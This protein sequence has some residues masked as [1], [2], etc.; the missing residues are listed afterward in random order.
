MAGLHKFEI[1]SWNVEGLC[2]P[3]RKHIVSKWMADQPGQLAFLCLQEIK[4]EGFRLDTTLSLI[5]PDH[6]AFVSL[7]ILGSGGTGGTAILVHPE[8]V[9][10]DLGGFQK[11]QVVWVIVEWKGC[12]FGVMNI[13]APNSSKD[14]KK[15]MEPD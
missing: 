6:R 1:T 12:R 10:V 8:I 13:Y 7:P 2:G 15:T 4:V 11:G 3:L 9:V 14:M 5:L